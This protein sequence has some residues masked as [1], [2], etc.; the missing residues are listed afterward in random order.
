MADMGGRKYA[1]L[2]NK[3]TERARLEPEMISQLIRSWLQEKA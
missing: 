3:L 2:K 1:I